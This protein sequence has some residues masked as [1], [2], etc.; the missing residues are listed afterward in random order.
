MNEDEKV[1]IYHNLENTRIYHQV[2]S[3]FIEISAEVRNAFFCRI[4]NLGDVFSN[5]TRS[6]TP[7]DYFVFIF[8]MAPAVEYLLHTYPEYV[9]VDSFPMDN[10]EEKVNLFTDRTI[11]YYHLGIRN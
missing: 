5:T 1:C 10:V 6:L 11:K 7:R 4:V 8:Q 3:Q 2:D 9:T